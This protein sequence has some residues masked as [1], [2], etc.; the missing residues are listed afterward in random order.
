MKTYAD[1]D[2]IE[3]VNGGGS[4]PA[5]WGI[6]WANDSLAVINFKNYMMAFEN[7]DIKVIAPMDPT[8]GRRYVEQVRDEAIKGWDHAYNISQD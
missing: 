2:V 6:G 5:M 7:Q 4:Y 8:E 1:F 3:V